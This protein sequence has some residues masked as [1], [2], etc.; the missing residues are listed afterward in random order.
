MLGKDSGPGRGSF[1]IMFSAVSLFAKSEPNIN[2]S[3]GL[4][5]NAMRRTLHVAF[6]ANEAAGKMAHAQGQIWACRMFRGRQARGDADSKTSFSSIGAMKSPALDG[7]PSVYSLR[8]SS[9]SP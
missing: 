3:A 9:P 4:C 1:I 8:P 6:A 2:A 7:V 5:V